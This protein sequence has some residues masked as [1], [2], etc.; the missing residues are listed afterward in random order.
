MRTRHVPVCMAFAL[1]AL[2]GP[3]RAL[4]DDEV[5]FDR[6]GLG[7][8]TDVLPAGGFIWEQGLADWERDRVAGGIR[9]S[10]V[11]AD[12]TWRFGLGAGLEL[13]LAGAPYQWQHQSGNADAG[14]SQGVG[15]SSLGLKAALPSSWD[16]FDWALLASWGLRTGAPGL[17]PQR[18]AQSAGVAGS[19]DLGG[20]RS[21][22]LYGNW[23]RD[24][25]G[26]GWLVSPS[27]GFGLGA[28]VSGYVEAGLGTGD[29][30]HRALGAGL[31]WTPRQRL[32]V[33]ASLLRGLL[34]GQGSWQAGL[35]LSYRFR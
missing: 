4:A 22:S 14:T 20:E 17:R 32:Q 10:Q 24:D 9:A 18:H 12:T 35:G 13:Q 3:G 26:H 21:L 2:V 28:Q 34:P 6:P 23:S 5:A 11:S 30:F 29:Q 7:F 15:D 27:Y 31:T 19:W 8:G 25:D 16:S 1:L 33:D